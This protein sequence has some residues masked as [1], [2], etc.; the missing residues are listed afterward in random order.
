VRNKVFKSLLIVLLALGCLGLSLSSAEAQ[1]STAEWPRVEIGAQVGPS[2]F[3]GGGVFLGAGPRLTLNVTPRDAVELTVD[4]L[5]GTEYSGIFGLYFVQY[6]RVVRPGDRRHS[7][8]FVTVAPGGTFRYYRSPERRHERADGSTV[9]HP[10]Y[11][12]AELGGPLFVS[13]GVGVER[14]LA[15]YVAA[16][17]EVQAVFSSVGVVGIRG[18]VGVSIPLGGY[19]DQGQ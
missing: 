5:S 17:A 2:M 1:V 15:R 10:A 8:I 16:R 12:S 3:V 9:I 19:G 14:V 11:T 13:G 4:I 6:K 18:V 7:A